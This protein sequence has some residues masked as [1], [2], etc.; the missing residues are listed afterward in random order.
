VKL[1]HASFGEITSQLFVADDPGNARDF[2]WRA[3]AAA[4]RPALEM[5]LQDAA[6]D[7]GLR[8]LARH[9]LVVPA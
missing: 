8:W 2:L 4:D 3:L 9:D 5:R 7:S 6:A 1:R